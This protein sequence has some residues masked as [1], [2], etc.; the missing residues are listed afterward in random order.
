MDVNKH[1]NFAQKRNY[2]TMLQKDEEKND[3]NNTAASI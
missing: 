2:D 1:L 3:K